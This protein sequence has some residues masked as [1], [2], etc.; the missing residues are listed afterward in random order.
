MNFGIS[1]RLLCFAVF[2]K[3][4]VITE[5]KVQEAK[6]FY[7]MHMKQTVFHEEGWRKIIEV[8]QY[9][10]SVGLSRQIHH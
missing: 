7:Q 4:Q 10:S 1:L 8:C 3:G 2:C 6:L 9:C 5:E